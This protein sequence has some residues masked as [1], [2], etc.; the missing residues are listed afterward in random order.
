MH[1]LEKRKKKARKKFK[2]QLDRQVFEDHPELRD[3]IGNYGD[4][5]KKVRPVSRTFAQWL[6][7]TG[8][9]LPITAWYIVDW[10]GWRRDLLPAKIVDNDRRGLISQKN[11]IRRVEVR[12]VGRTGWRYRGM[13][14]LFFIP[15]VGFVQNPWNNGL[16]PPYV[17]DF[18]FEQSIHGHYKFECDGISPKEAYNPNE[19]F[20]L[21]PE[22]IG[23]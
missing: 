11:A 3:I 17:D 23:D 12:P 4:P 8:D 2:K 10:D 18:Y 9:D 7:K 16:D 21:T 20:G 5:V 22:M 1:E 19:D 15:V 14:L 6:K 13:G